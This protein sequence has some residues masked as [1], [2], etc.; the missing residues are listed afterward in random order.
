[1]DQY[2]KQLALKGSTVSA[3]LGPST[4]VKRFSF[5]GLLT[6]SGGQTKDLRHKLARK[7]LGIPIKVKHLPAKQ[8]RR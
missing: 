4:V 1:M 5:A 6:I 3:R 8:L 7:P 2:S